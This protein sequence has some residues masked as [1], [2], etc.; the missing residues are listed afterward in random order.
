M[1]TRNHPLTLDLEGRAGHVVGRIKYLKEKIDE[2][3][4]VLDDF[5]R[6][7]VHASN[8]QVKQLQDTLQLYCRKLAASKKE[9]DKLSKEKM[10]IEHARMNDVERHQRAIDKKRKRGRIVTAK[11]MEQHLDNREDRPYE[12]AGQDEQRPVNSPGEANRDANRDVV[13]SLP[14]SNNGMRPRGMPPTHQERLLTRLH[15]SED[16]RERLRTG[17]LPTDPFATEDMDPQ[18]DQSYTTEQV[19]YL[20]RII[21]DPRLV[22]HYPAT[23]AYLERLKLRHGVFFPVMGRAAK[24]TVERYYRIDAGTH[25]KWP[26]E[27]QAIHKDIVQ[28]AKFS[29]LAKLV[30]MMVTFIPAG[31]YTTYAAIKDWALF[32]RDGMLPESHVIAACN[33]GAKHYSLEDVP[34]HR[35]VAHDSA[36]HLD[37]C[38]WGVHLPALGDDTRRAIFED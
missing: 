14:T 12:H 20:E 8:A 2:V 18:T 9:Q 4:D 13:L 33:K 17:R 7:G 38:D 32:A 5:V 22:E 35:V 3:A 24:T 10:R 21:T 34:L 26:L 16:E 31:R 36:V 1:G 23:K 15:Q 29:D 6:Q 28:Q 30:L 27:M 11:C 25:N 19:V 37:L